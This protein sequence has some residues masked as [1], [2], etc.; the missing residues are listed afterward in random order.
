MKD[1]KRKVEKQHIHQAIIEVFPDDMNKNNTVFVGIGTDRSTG[2]SLGPMVGTLL[3]KNGYRVYGTL[4]N[5]VHAMN[6]IETIAKLHTN[7]KGKYI[8]AIDACLGK[9]ISLGL[10]TVQKGSVRP[11][12]GVGKELPPVGD[13]AITSIVNVSGFMEY[14]VLQNTRLS[15]V[16]ELAEAICE[17]LDKRFSESVYELVA[18]AASE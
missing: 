13:Y 4:K 16:M 6:L 17:A 3:K 9:H 8:V 1:L 5:P 15:T 7:E 18:S 2:D 14:F 12:A 10:T 11:G